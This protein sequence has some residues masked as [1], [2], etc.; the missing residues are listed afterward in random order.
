MARDVY[1]HVYVY[2]LNSRQRKIKNPDKG[3]EK[4]KVEKENSLVSLIVYA[5]GPLAPW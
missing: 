1:A 3:E 4:Q 5:V 2:E